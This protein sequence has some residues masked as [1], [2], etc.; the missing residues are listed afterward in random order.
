RNDSARIMPTH[1]AGTMMRAASERR[2]TLRGY[3]GRSWVPLHPPCVDAV[4]PH[5]KTDRA[6]DGENDS[7]DPEHPIAA[8]DDADESKDRGKREH[9]R[10]VLPAQRDDQ[11]ERHK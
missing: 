4:H 10:D 9:N 8:Q 11:Q 5:E 6:T 1:T 3:R 7:H 2:F